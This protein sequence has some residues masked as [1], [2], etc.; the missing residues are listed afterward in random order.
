MLNSTRKRGFGTASSTP[1]GEE[2]VAAGAPAPTS[3]AAATSGGRQF[4]TIADYFK[5]QPGG[6]AFTSDTYGDAKLLEAARRAGLPTIGIPIGENQEFHVFAIQKGQ[7]L[8]SALLQL[9][10][11]PS[12]NMA[13]DPGAVPGI[14]QRML[15]QLIAEGVAADAAE[16]ELIRLGRN[17]GILQ[18]A[19]FGQRL[20]SLERAAK[21]FQDN[22][23]LMQGAID[24]GY[25]PNLGG[26]APAPVAP[27]A[28]AGGGGAPPTPPEVPNGG[29]VDWWA[30]SLPFLEDTGIT[31]GQAAWAGGGTAAA[32]ALAALLAQN[33][34]P[35]MDPAAYAAYQ[36]SANSY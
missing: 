13:S 2:G 22:P 6:E 16:Q 29:E 17:A 9:S 14:K 20:R 11:K 12:G 27:A 36:Q 25:L 10:K 3:P 4:N 8:E 35:Q 26:A 15:D 31:R 34:Q 33:G 1:P 24:A 30:Q 5:R 23:A 19:A 18:E 28:A 7:D 32:L 21:T